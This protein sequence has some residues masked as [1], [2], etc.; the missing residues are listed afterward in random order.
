M[1]SA[2]RWLA[3]RVALPLSDRVS[4]RRISSRLAHL[5]AQQWWS[6]DRIETD[7]VARLR[8]LLEH[9]IAHVPYYRRLL[10][11][12]GVRPAA[13]RSLGDLSRVPVSTK[14][15]LRAA[16]LEQ[17][18][19]ESLPASR[20][21][22]SITSGSSGMPFRFHFDMAAEDTRLA[23]FM[24]ALEWAGVGVWDVEI[25][26]GSPFRDASWRY[27]RV[28]S[29]GQLGRR[30][31]LGQRAGRLQSMRPTPEE[32][33]RLVREI[34]GRR[35]WFLRAFPSMLAVL[36]DQ[37][38]QSGLDLPA[39]PRAVISR[40]E[41]LTAVRRATIERAFRRSP[42][43]HYACNEMAHVAQSCPDAPS[44]FHV[45]GDR[46]IVHVVRADGRPAGP[47][48]TGRV[49]LTDLE[50]RVM[51]FINY[52]VGDRATVGAPCPCRRGLA[53]LAT[54]DGR[55]AEVI[56][57][58]AGEQ[59]SAFTLE[60]CINAECDVGALSE[61]QIV[62]TALERVVVRLVTT[63]RFTRDEAR[64]LRRA[65]EKVLGPDVSVDLE[66]VASI[67]PEPS[68][69]RLVVKTEVPL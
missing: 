47:G 54:V 60:S 56:R 7:A 33:S 31:F 59:L 62:Q 44:G 42:V 40:G 64:R 69:K 27:P 2:R 66:E 21:W 5:Q 48:E 45:L 63:P 12:A 20:R 37:V 18:T 67:P 52:A 25:K 19:A 10:G 41:T 17:T 3:A 22:T 49:L 14:A 43:D 51:P 39:Y 8:G 55:E 53:S 13:I 38:I 50:N 9:A 36:G 68:G 29:L 23:T 65:F 28:G 4:G 32:L 26:I 46:I 34:A 24:L 11:E 6:P 1:R 35:A 16:G 58:P 57:L 30:V 15:A 61:F